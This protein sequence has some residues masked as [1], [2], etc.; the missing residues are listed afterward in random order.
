MGSVAME[1]QANGEGFEL[2][3]ELEQEAGE[4]AGPRLEDEGAIGPTT[5]RQDPTQSCTSVS[6]LLYCP[7]QLHA[8]PGHDGDEGA[9]CVEPQRRRRHAGGARAPGGRHTTEL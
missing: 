8:A 4:E 5:C 1:G 2:E 9:D 6:G 3:Q 7:P